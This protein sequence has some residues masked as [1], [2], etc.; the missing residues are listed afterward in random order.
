[1]AY[2][3]IEAKRAQD[4]DWRRRKRAGLTGPN[5]PPKTPRKI[6]NARDVIG[7]LEYAAREV[8]STHTDVLAK[9]R[10]LTYISTMLLKAIEVD[11]LEN[12]LASLEQQL[13]L[14]AVE[15]APALPPSATAQIEDASEQLLSVCITPENTEANTD[16]TTNA[17]EDNVP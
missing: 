1:M 10:C 15:D 9:A 5:A 8:E 13:G 11:A 14:V 17:T 3:D 6:A 16:P 7:L 4:R 12:R 2:K